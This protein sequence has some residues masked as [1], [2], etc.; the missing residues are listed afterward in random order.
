MKSNTHHCHWQRWIHNWF[1]SLIWRINIFSRHGCCCHRRRHTYSLTWEGFNNSF[2]WFVF[3][4]CLVSKSDS[5]I[6]FE[7]LSELCW[8]VPRLYFLHELLVFRCHVVA[9]RLFIDLEPIS[10]QCDC[11]I[12]I[13][14]IILRWCSLS[15][16]ND[17]IKTV[18]VF[19]YS[20]GST[21]VPSLN[22]F[23][24]SFFVYNNKRVY[25][26]SSDN[27]QWNMIFVHFV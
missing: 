2:W 5:N 20:D 18:L 15:F 12:G 1:K 24:I 17:I 14:F 22:L 23:L 25:N 3:L 11:D 4:F 13:S 16:I 19:R 9:E 27:Q 21:T 7:L 10:P 8:N 26:S 6:A